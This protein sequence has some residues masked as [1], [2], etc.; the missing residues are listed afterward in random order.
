MPAGIVFPVRCALMIGANY[1][2]NSQLKNVGIKH[3]VKKNKP[4]INNPLL[5]RTA[6]TFFAMMN[7]RLK[8]PAIATQFSPVS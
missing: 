1:A 3:V 8:T 6:N 2:G 7:Q 4:A 5:N